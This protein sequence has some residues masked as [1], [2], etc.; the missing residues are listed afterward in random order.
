DPVEIFQ[1]HH[2]RLNPTL[3]EEQPLQRVERELPALGRLEVSKAI[4]LRQRMEQPEKRR[5]Q[6]PESLVE[7]EQMSGRLG[8]NRA[9][10]VTLVDA[11]IRLQKLDDGE[12]AGG[13]AIRDGAGLE[14]PKWERTMGTDQLVEHARLAYTR[15]T[16]DGHDLAVAVSRRVEG[17]VKLRQLRIPSNEAAQAPLGG[18]L[19]PVSHGAR[20]QHFE[21]LDGG[22]EALH[23]HRT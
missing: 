11:E 1:H 6:I 21:D 3:A 9:D 23:R 13:P 8:A 22:V 19:N 15:L 16:H 4:V 12:I 14:R 7:R 10:V 17:R 18:S 5:E 2:E 20:R